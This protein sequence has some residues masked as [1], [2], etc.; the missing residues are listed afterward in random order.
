LW[1]QRAQHAFYLAEKQRELTTALKKLA[2][3]RMNWQIAIGRRLS[4][5]RQARQQWCIN[6]YP[7]RCI[8]AASYQLADGALPDS[9]TYQLP[10]GAPP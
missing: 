3:V 6:W 8:T 9:D 10:D 1:S 7:F 5:A 4:L 2:D